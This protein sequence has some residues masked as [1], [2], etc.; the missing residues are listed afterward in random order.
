MIIGIY[1]ITNIETNMVYIGSSFNVK[2]RLNRHLAQLKKQKHFNKRLQNSF[3]VHGHEK[4]TFAI[5]EICDDKISDKE[6]RELE[7]K[8]ITLAGLE[9][10]YN[11]CPVAGST[12]GR[13]HSEETKNKISSA[14]MGRKL[15]ESVKLYLSTINKGKKLSDET[16]KKLSEI[17]KIKPSDRSKK[18]AQICIETGITIKIF[19]NGKEASESTGIDSASISRV[20]HEKSKQAGGFKWK[21]TNGK[22]L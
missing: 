18:V 2:T 20:C 3:N 9:N 12:K 4:F 1:S 11:H 17:R 15:S 7:N 14:N 22:T 10:C 8:Y 21:F 13:K 19:S 5:L 6:L 16:K